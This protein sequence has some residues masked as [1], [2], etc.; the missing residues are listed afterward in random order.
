MIGMGDFFM[1]EKRKRYRALIVDDSAMNREI[2]KEILKDDME[3]FE[4]C[5]G[6]EAMNMLMDRFQQLDVV[7]LD[8]M[9]P[10]VNGFEVLEFMRGKHM[11]DYLP[12]IAI[13][14]DDKEPNIERAFDLGAIDFIAR[15]YSE[16][17]ILRRVLTTVS[18][19]SKQKTLVAE[20]DRQYLVGDPKV[21]RLTG[22]D[23]KQ[24]F[25]NNVYSLLRRN[26]DVELMMV[27]ADI[28]NFK[29]YNNYYGWEKGDCYLQEYAKKLK[30][31][32]Q[33]FGGYVGYMG[34]DDFALLV[35]HTPAILEIIRNLAEDGSR[36]EFYQPGFAPKFGIYVIERGMESAQT[37]YDRAERAL[38]KIKNDYTRGVCIYE[39]E[40]SAMGGDEF[41]ML[42]DIRRGEQNREF[43]FFVQPICDLSTGEVVGGEALVRWIHKDKGLVVPGAFVPSLERTGFISG[44]DVIIWGQVCQW[45]RQQLDAG[46]P[47][48]PISVNVSKADIYMLD[49]TGV[50]D[51]LMEQYQLDRKLLAVE[52][53]EEVYDGDAER[54]AREMTKLHRS[55]YRVYLDDYGKGRFNL[56]S[57]KDLEIDQLK[58]DMG[59]LELEAE[60]VDLAVSIPEFVIRLAKKRGITTVAEGVENTDQVDLLQKLDC[61]LVQGYHFYRPMPAKDFAKL[62][63]S[64]N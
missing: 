64:E 8:L 41:Q 28:A 49:V 42:I 14:V 15:P 11:T 53:S 48:V 10:G 1:T 62:I 34:G 46:A 4:A 39:Q 47:M 51:G 3:I 38:Y 56:L 21:D 2:L 23:L 36:F 32:A 18:L 50:L 54:L 63:S 30:G 55:G 58:L 43:E 35:P 16:R 40:M 24:T 44:V 37:M 20:I 7:L 57:M 45:M 17:T 26:E 13:S 22:V 6:E 25:F 9:M 12:V 33:Q 29:L 19:F 52:I 31:I 59:F 5:G 27:A 61:D 60:G